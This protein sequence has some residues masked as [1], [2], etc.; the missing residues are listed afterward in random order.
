[1]TDEERPCPRCET[2]L[3]VKVLQV[4][5]VKKIMYLREDPCP[6]CKLPASR[7]ENFYTAKKK[8]HI[9]TSKKGYF[10]LDPRG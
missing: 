9:Q 2:I 6:K 8:P 10:K 4:H 5:N 1:M 3:P 7:I